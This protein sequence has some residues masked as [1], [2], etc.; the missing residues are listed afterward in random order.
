M[1]FA[2][3][4]EQQAALYLRECLTAAGGNATQAAKDAGLHRSRFYRRCAQLGIPTSHPRPSH[5]IS[6]FASWRPPAAPT[7][8]RI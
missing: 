6:H 3:H 2:E 1:T 8:V 7:G 4:L 5:A